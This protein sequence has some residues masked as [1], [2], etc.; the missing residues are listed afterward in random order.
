MTIIASTSDDRQAAQSKPNSPA[1]PDEARTWDAAHFA[2]LPTVVQF[3]DRDVEEWT[4][5]G[6]KRYRMAF[7][8]VATP[9]GV[10]R[11]KIRLRRG[12]T[13]TDLDEARRW[14]EAAKAGR[15]SA[16]EEHTNVATGERYW[17]FAAGVRRRQDDTAYLA[18]LHE[19][20]RAGCVD[21]FHPYIDEGKQADFHRSECIEHPDGLYSVGL[22]CAD[23]EP[24]VVFVD[25]S[26]L[27][28]VEGPPVVRAVKDLVNDVA[29]LETECEH[30]NA[31][32]AAAA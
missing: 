7:A 19:C 2:D 1:V 28:A 13:S 23:D 5:P 21:D 25:V 6:G 27:E 24:W 3:V 4:V 29:R 11:F 32:T 15:F 17:V 18:V 14:I 10:S 20:R 9:T 30:L 8:I 31:K 16:W 22:L 12:A 26:N